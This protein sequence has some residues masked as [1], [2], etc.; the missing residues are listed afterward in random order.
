MTA[1]PFTHPE[2]NCLGVDPNLFFPEQGSPHDQVDKA[3]AICATC[4]A[5]QACLDHALE[6]GE[7]G[8]WG[9]TTG[10]QRRQ[11]VTLKLSTPPSRAK[12]GAHTFNMRPPGRTKTQILA[13]LQAHRGWVH[14]SVVAERVGIQQQSVSRAMARLRDEGLVDHENGG[15]YR[16]KATV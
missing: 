11:M 1:P 13:E 8:I 16:F 9:G 15:Y 10:R 5:R 6:Y 14:A 3:L 4:P 7:P 2:A 12:R